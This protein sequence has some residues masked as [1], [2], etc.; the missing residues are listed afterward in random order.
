MHIRLQSTHLWPHREA[1]HHRPKHKVFPLDDRR[2]ERFNSDLAGRPSLI[3]GNSQ[4]RFGGIVRLTENVVLNVK[5]KSPAVTADLTVTGGGA[6]G[7]VVAQGGALGGWSI[8]LH[9]GR[10]T[11]CYNLFGM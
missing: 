6:D 3:R 4:V 1:A 10:P 11:Y 7:V 5:N 8:Y 9:E 2:I